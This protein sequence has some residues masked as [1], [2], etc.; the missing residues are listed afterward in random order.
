MPLA[1]RKQTPQLCSQA[2]SQVSILIV[3][4]HHPDCRATQGNVGLGWRGAGLLPLRW[5][6]KRTFRRWLGLAGSRLAALGRS[7][8]RSR[9]SFTGI[10]SS[11][12]P[13]SVA[14]RRQV[15]PPIADTPL[16]TTV[17]PPSV[18]DVGSRPRWREKSFVGDHE[19]LK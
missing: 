19:G 2:V 16:L 8:A 6:E 14:R 13:A 18:S 11:R 17:G 4:R 7:T 3:A 5:R 12:R 15:R 10:A 1:N 9:R